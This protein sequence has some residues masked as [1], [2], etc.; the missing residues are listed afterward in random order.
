MAPQSRCETGGTGALKTIVELVQLPVTH[1]VR[2]EV[3]TEAVPPTSSG[4]SRAV[5]GHDI[6]IEFFGEPMST[7]EAVRAPNACPIDNHAQ[8]SGVLTRAERAVAKTGELRTST[9]VESGD[10]HSHEVP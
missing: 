9:A 4:G 3:D 2:I 10:D 8:E 7:E 6:A 1:R 5:T